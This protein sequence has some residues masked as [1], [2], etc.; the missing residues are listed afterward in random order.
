ML[1]W[2]AEAEKVIPIPTKVECLSGIFAKQA[3]LGFEH[4]VAVT[5][6]ELRK[7]RF[8]FIY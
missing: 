5:G 4:S 8:Y 3:A 2:Y 6:L 7:D 1:Y